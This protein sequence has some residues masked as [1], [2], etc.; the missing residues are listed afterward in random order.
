MLQWEKVKEI[1]GLGEAQGNDDKDVSPSGAGE[2]KQ[3]QADSK[4]ISWIDFLGLYDSWEIK[5][6]VQKT[7]IMGYFLCA[8][9]KKL[10]DLWVSLELPGDGGRE[11]RYIDSSTSNPNTHKSIPC[12][13]LGTAMF[14]NH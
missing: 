5:K 8:S 1:L 6:F 11:L 2:E 7:S 3:G 9:I 4:G 12:W 13:F 10:P 14:G